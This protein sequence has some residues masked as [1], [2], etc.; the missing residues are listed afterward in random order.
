MLGMAIILDLQEEEG[1]DEPDDEV[2]AKSI[3]CAG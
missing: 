3:R 2:E 1:Y